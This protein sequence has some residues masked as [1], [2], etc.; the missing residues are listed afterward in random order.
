MFKN[1]NPVK[2][3]YFGIAAFLTSLLADAFIGANVSVSYLDITPALFS[4][5]NMWTALLYCIS[6]PLSFTLGVLGLVR[7]ADSRVLAVVAIILV[8]I[9]FT[10]LLT[11]LIS[12]ISFR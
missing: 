2:K 9:P 3:T 10:F 1:S 5:L 4:Q 11:G 7:Q 8:M 6:M 12:A